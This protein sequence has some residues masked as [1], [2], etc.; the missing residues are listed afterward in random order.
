MESLQHFKKPWAHDHHPLKTLLE[1]VKVIT[2]VY[3][4]LC[5][6]IDT[7]TCTHQEYFTT[8]SSFGW[9]LNNK[10]QSRVKF[11]FE[12]KAPICTTCDA[13]SHKTKEINNINSTSL[14][15]LLD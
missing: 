10:M 5:I 7:F 13:W 2:H 9:C 12:Q 11:S 8:P 4:L 6:S 1:A 3:F 15:L 14:F